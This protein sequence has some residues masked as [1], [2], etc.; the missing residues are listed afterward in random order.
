MSGP[1]KFG[2]VLKCIGKPKVAAGSG[3]PLLT[4]S[5]HARE[6]YSSE[7]S[8]YL[9]VTITSGNLRRFSP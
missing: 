9:S 4:L 2:S 3:N 7:F 6:G 5:A 8:V 1:D